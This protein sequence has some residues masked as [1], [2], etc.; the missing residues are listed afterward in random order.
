[1]NEERYPAYLN[2]I[3]T[4]LICPSGKEPEVLGANQY[5]IDEGLVQVM[6]QMATTL[7]TQGDLDKADFLIEI[8]NNLVES[9]LWLT[10]IRAK[11]TNLGE[12]VTQSPA[13]CDFLKIVLQTSH[14]SNGSPQILYPLLI[15]NLN[16]LNDDFAQLLY[17]SVTAYLPE[18]S[19]EI[20][21]VIASV[22]GTFS[23]RIQDFPLGN[24]AS[25]F[26]IAIAGYK[27]VATVFTRK[28]SPATWAMGQNNLSIAYRNRIRGNKAENLETAIAAAKKALQ[29][30]TLK[31]FSEAGAM[32]HINLG[33]AYFERILGNRGENLET[34]ITCYNRALS[35]YTEEAFS[36]DWA[37]VQNNLSAAYRKRIQGERAEN[38]E[39]AIATSKAALSV[40]AQEEFPNDWAQA[41]NNLA[42]AYRER[43]KGDR[44][45]NLEL[46]LG[47]YEQALQVYTREAFP[48]EWANIQN[49][50]GNVYSQRI[51]GDKA[52][53]LEQAISTYQLALQIHTCEELPHAWANI[54]NNLGNVYTNRICGDKAENLE[55]ALKALQAALKVYTCEAFPEQW[56]ILQFN[57]VAIY[58]QR[59]RGERAENLERA[60]TSGKSA[61]QVYTREA[62]PERWAGT[63]TNLGNAYDYQGQVDEAIERLRLALEVYTPTA[64]PTDCL[65]TGRNLG[66]IAFTAGRWT[67]AIEGY[68]V[69]IEA[70]EQSRAWAGIDQRKQEVLQDAIGVYIRIVQAYINNKQP[71]RAIEYV[72]R[73]KARNL[74]EILATRDLYPKGKFTETVLN[75]LD[76]LRREI[77]V[78]LQRID[79]SK[80][81]VTID[82]GH[83][84]LPV[85]GSTNRTRLN[86]LRQQLDDLIAQ[87]I[88][89]I[90]PTFSLTQRVEPI[91]FRQIREL[92]P[93]DKTALIEWGAGGDRLDTFIVTHRSDRPIVM[94]STPE[95]IKAM[96]KWIREYLDAYTQQ[97]DQWQANLE[98]LL[99]QLANLLQIERLISFLPPE[100]NQLILI[101]GRLL[102][103]LPLH[104]LPIN[105]QQSA[106]NSSQFT[107]LDKFY[108]GVRYAPSCQLLQLTQSTSFGN[109]QSIEAL[110]QQRLFGI[111]NPTDDLSYTDVEVATIRQIFHPHDEVLVKGAARKAEINNQRLRQVNYA[112]FSCHGY[113]NFQEPKLSA[114]LLADCELSPAEAQEQ[115]PI[116]PIRYLLSEDG[117]AI[118][119]EKCLTLGEIFAL[120]MK[121]CRLVTLSA[122]ETGLTEFI[123]L[124]DEYISLP[125]GFLFAGSPSVVSTIWTVNDLS[126]AFLMIKFYQNLQAVDSVAVAL[127]QAQL[128]LRDLT[129]A[130]L[131]AWIATNSLPLDPTMRRHLNKRLHRFQD[132][133]KLFQNPFHWAAFC[134]LGQ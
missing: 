129:K 131:K 39:Q 49:N 37:L 62:F 20:A 72:E 58:C 92:L 118:D 26:E 25:H 114:L 61:L 52:E 108:G 59:L 29:V 79:L 106:A 6:E 122:C 123:T 24:K 81:D 16:K 74:V 1:M 46:A 133:Q 113:F 31:Q 3:D 13:Q 8:A 5:L 14:L 51:Q 47:Y 53:N 105:S 50:L 22:V 80:F 41:Q 77:A 115:V 19:P 134:A 75:Q 90:D 38:L 124:T 116:N 9:S 36:E 23:N 78:E 121:N 18:V 126:T 27:V 125:S 35:V 55:S 128:W 83:S 130:E 17:S 57:L 40:Y 21:Q 112:H 82:S 111:Q 11:T 89:P 69:A 102:N 91:S 103:L 60:I 117:G 48:S 85:R 87:Q 2:L 56:A 64:F 76:R 43:I 73:S 97:K 34:A 66:N 45:E 104:A 110:I 32:A 94:S 132:D 84:Q 33:S 93:D 120:D 86:T 68:G 119:L 65:T 107:L 100:C 15:A 7:T 67:E 30:Y 4:L 98:E 63:Q 88:Q 101:P 71:D 109:A 42:S 99:K 70:V 54:Q 12:T 28:V 95:E 10:G 96:D 44:N 127:N